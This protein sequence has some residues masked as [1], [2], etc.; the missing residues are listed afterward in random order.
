MSA[1]AVMIALVGAM[2]VA[3]GPAMAQTA[4]CGASQTLKAARAADGAA[5]PPVTAVAAEQCTIPVGVTGGAAEVTVNG[6]GDAVHIGGGGADAALTITAGGL[7]NQE[8][9]ETG[10]VTLTVKWAVTGPP[11]LSSEAKTYVITVESHSETVDTT[12][13]SVT[14]EIDDTDDTVSNAFTG[15]YP[16]TITTKKIPALPATSTEDPV[17]PAITVYV[18][19]ELDNVVINVDEPS[20]AA[21]L[22]ADQDE[23][24]YT[25]RIVVPQGTTP[26][27]YTLSVNLYRVAVTT[28]ADGTVVLS[29]AAVAPTGDPEAGTTRDSKRYASSDVLTVGGAGDAIGSASLTLG[30]SKGQNTPLDSTDDTS[31]SGS[32][33]STGEINLSLAITNSL[34][35][36]A[37]SGDIKEILVVAPRASVRYAD[38]TG[39]ALGDLKSLPSDGRIPAD[40]S[41][42]SMLLEVKSADGSPRGIDIYVIVLGTSSSK[43]SDT[44][45]LT[46]AGSLDALAAGEASSTVLAHDVVGDDKDAGQDGESS[47]DAGDADKDADTRDQIV[48]TV[49]ATDAAGNVLATPPLALKI[50][51]PD[52]KVVNKAKF[53]DGNA[54]VQTGALKNKVHLDIDTG[55][56]A[57]LKTGEYEITFSSGSKKATSS[58]TVVGTAHSVEIMATEA[59]ENGQ[60]DVTVKVSADEDGTP[61]A[62][63]TTVTIQ[64]AD[65][66][67]DDDQVLYL[68]SSEGKT[69]AGVAKATFIEIGPGRAAIIAMADGK[70]DVERV[71]ST[72]D[73]PVVEEPEPEVAS[74]ACLSNLNGFATWACGVESSASE[75]FGLVSGRGATAIHLWN[76]SA[77]VRYSVVD[78]TMV[79]GSSDFMVAENDILYISN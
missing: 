30:V 70:S 19:G 49:D 8:G 11:A 29:A 41:V 15:S 54:P 57:P 74:V 39:K 7:E 25:G 4:P 35:N 37:N 73:A 2:F 77:W 18:S 14:L 72:F 71:T 43:N 1:L 3:L 31:E 17:V 52:G 48:F 51:D 46:F 13:R 6:D 78:G 62:D 44:V 9:T 66:R 67:G 75:I 32:S 64:E 59:N 65:L 56:T 21:Q 42:S 76:G 23:L 58:F 5:T 12:V 60:I 53:N 20:A 61:V 24:K 28:T 40:D 33:P 79:P 27:E 50:T 22:T 63:G 68:T 10:T 45:A 38:A 47:K 16:F 55:A 26:G 34:G 36:P 69:K